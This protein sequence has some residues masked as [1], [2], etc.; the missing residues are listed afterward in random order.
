[1]IGPEL[2]ATVQETLWDRGISQADLAR[3]TGLTEATISRFL[4]GEREA[5]FEVI[6]KILDALGLEVVIRPRRERKGE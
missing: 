6:D 2:R 4:H 3:A 1:M 5:S